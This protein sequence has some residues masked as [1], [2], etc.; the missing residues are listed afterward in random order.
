MKR[1]VYTLT[2]AL[3]LLGLLVPAVSHAGSSERSK[4]SAYS[5]QDESERL[6][7]QRKPEPCDIQTAW[8]L[9][10][11]VGIL[12]H[13]LNWPVSGQYVYGPIVKADYRSTEPDRPLTVQTPD[14]WKRLEKSDR[15]DTDDGGWAETKK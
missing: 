12:F 4:I 5:T 8:T 2:L 6:V 10:S 13:A 1:V 3:I 7:L 14:W 11:F 15:P 9:R